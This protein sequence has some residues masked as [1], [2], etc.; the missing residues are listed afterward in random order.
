MLQ[1]RDQPWDNLWTSAAQF[2]L[3]QINEIPLPQEVQQSLISQTYLNIPVL[4]CVCF[5]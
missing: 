1:M 5:G 4:V 3:A 2:F